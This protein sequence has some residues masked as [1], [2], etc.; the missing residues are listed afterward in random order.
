M[1]EQL[2]RGEELQGF[3]RSGVRGVFTSVGT[4]RLRRGALGMVRGER[5]RGARVRRERG[6]IR[7]ERRHVRVSHRR[8]VRVPRLGRRVVVRRRGIVYVSRDFVRQAIVDVR[9]HFSRTRHR[10]RG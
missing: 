8:S 3:L 9:L 4:S 1:V 6:E 7:R 5:A 2:R 10:E